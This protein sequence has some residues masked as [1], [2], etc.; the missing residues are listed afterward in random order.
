MSPVLLWAK[1]GPGWSWMGL[2]RHL[3][4]TAAV[5]ERTTGT[6]LARGARPPMTTLTPTPRLPR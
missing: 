1:T 4:D 6:V 5:A 3:L 2:R